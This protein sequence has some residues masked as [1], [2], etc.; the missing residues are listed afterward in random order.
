MKAKM[1]YVHKKDRCRCG[2]LKGVESKR[3]NTCHR[4]K[5]NRGAHRW[6]ARKDK[7]ANA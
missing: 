2:K 5:R 3:C 1:I 6:W 7:G 4:S